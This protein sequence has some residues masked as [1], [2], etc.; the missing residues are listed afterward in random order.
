MSGRSVALIVEEMSG[1]LHIY[2]VDRGRA[3][4]SVPADAPDEHI[5]SVLGHAALAAL[6]ATP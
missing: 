3:W 2:P 5:V 1:K 6:R 4:S